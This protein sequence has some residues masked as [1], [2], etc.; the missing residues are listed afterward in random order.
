MRKND[1]IK[2]LQEAL[3]FIKLK[4]LDKYIKKRIG[5][6]NKLIQLL[7]FSPIFIALIAMI[8]HPSTFL[9]YLSLGASSVIILQRFVSSLSEIVNH[10]DLNFDE[11]QDLDLSQEDETLD[12]INQFKLPNEEEFYS[13]KMY[14]YIKQNREEQDRYEEE[15]KFQQSRSKFKIYKSNEEE[16]LTKEEVIEKFMYELEAYNL[17]TKIPPVEISTDEWNLFFDTLYNLL[18]EKNYTSEFYNITSKLLRL[19][20]SNSLINKTTNI[21]LKDFTDSLDYLNK[22]YNFFKIALNNQE[23]AELQIN[24]LSKVKHPKIIKFKRK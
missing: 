15:L 7:I 18:I 6:K 3:N 14:N 9:L 10:K 24:I 22:K 8:K 4:E 17:G 19:T 21:S 13:D 16:E 2:P 23:I 5:L 11:F 1:E 20:I 12:I